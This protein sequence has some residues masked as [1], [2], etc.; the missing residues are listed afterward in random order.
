M[1]NFLRLLLLILV[2]L[3]QSCRLKDASNLEKDAVGPKEE[4]VNR[5]E[6]NS[7]WKKME[8]P[9]R[10]DEIEIHSA[11]MQFDSEGNIHLVVQLR[12]YEKMLEAWKFKL[13]YFYQKNGIW[14]RTDLKEEMY[15]FYYYHDSNRFNKFIN[16]HLKNDGNLLIFYIDM[17]KNLIKLEQ[18]NGVVNEVVFKEKVK[19]FKTLFDTDDGKI[20]LVYMSDERGLAKDLIIKEML[21][22]GS[23][24]SQKT[25]SDFDSDDYDSNIEIVKNDDS[26]DIFL[27]A[28]LDGVPKERLI[29][30]KNFQIIPLAALGTKNAMFNVILKDEKFKMCF[31]DYEN[32]RFEFSI[33]PQNLK[34]DVKFLPME[35]FSN[36]T[37]HCYLSHDDQLPLINFDINE[38]I[39]FLES[40]NFFRNEVNEF[41]VDLYQINFLKVFNSKIAIVGLSNEAKR[42]V[43]LL[44][45]NH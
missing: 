7:G 39:P 5:F 1:K 28:Y 26:I 4:E 10:L 30:V 15:E 25:L 8:L 37:P 18:V 29:L 36:L 35:Y 16:F 24:V 22:D 20:H 21:I 27:N 13:T 19:T 34:S 2:A 11:D 32:K 3:L 42:P 41:K 40:Y 45:D 44:K 43:V 23:I 9:S 17:N 38:S 33:D 12:E 6:G 14:K 31:V